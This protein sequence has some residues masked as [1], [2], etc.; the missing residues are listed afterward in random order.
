MSLADVADGVMGGM[1]RFRQL[2]VAI[3]REFAVPVG[4]HR[5]IRFID[6]VQRCREGFLSSVI[7]PLFPQSIICKSA[8]TG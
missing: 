8:I 7:F 4:N 2:A 6:R 3:V 1:T 5:R